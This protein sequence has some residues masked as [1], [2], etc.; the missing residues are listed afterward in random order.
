MIKFERIKNQDY[1]SKNEIENKLKFN[2][3]AKNQNKK[4]NIEGQTRNIIK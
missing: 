4:W 1:E 2:Y 3:R